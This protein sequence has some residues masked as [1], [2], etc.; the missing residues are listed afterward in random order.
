MGSERILASARGSGDG[1]NVC[2]Y[3]AMNIENHAKIYPILRYEKKNALPKEALQK[4]FQMNVS[5]LH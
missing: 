5:L 3:W 2:S 4:H 1:A